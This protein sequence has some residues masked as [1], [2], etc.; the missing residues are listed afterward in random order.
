MNVTGRA[1]INCT[2]LLSGRSRSRLSSSASSSA[3]ASASGI[4]SKC[5]YSSNVNASSNANA[6]NANASHSPST[7]TT[8]ATNTTT[9]TNVNETNAQ[10]SWNEFF[11]LRRRL[12]LFK[13]F[14]GGIPALFAFFTAEGAL[15][16]LPLFDPTAPIFGVDPLVMVGLGTAVGAVASFA[17]GSAVAGLAWRLCSPLRAS[18]FDAKQRSFY[19]RVSAFRA[20]V[21]PNPTQM[22]F[23]F[24][25]Y[26]EKVASVQDY[27]RW[28]RRQ[29][30]LVS[31][32]QFK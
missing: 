9:T 28:L 8:N 4:V 3:S 2:K 29:K 23:S 24:D 13:R 7:S 26:G 16:S 20:N 15:L 31:E 11:R 10:L 30:Q 5:N 17:V 32:R 22:N 19:H 18:L 6:T 14:A 21:P 12:T 27:R 25:F 1:V